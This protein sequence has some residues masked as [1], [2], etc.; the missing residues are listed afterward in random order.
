MLEIN[1]NYDPASGELKDPDPL[2]LFL[3]WLGAAGSVA[4]LVGVFD[5]LKTKRDGRRRT[6]RQHVELVEATT[7]LESDLTQL[8]GQIQKMDLLMRLASGSSAN[9]TPMMQPLNLRSAPFRF[10]AIQ[11]NLPG[12][13]LREWYRF[14]RETCAI[15]SRLGR[16]VHRLIILLS[17]TSWRLRSETHH[18]FVQLRIE[19]NHVLSSETFGAAAEQCHVAI[20]TGREAGARLRADLFEG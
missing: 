12:Q 2:S 19:L 15:A 20:K 3:L 6:E 8:E 4:S 9:G 18:A 11:L 1:E 17:E 10:G 16:S 5:Q 7:Q 14:H 13:M